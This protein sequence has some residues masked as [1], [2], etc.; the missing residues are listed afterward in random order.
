M[1]IQ[2]GD[3]ETD[4]TGQ[5]VGLNIEDTPELYQQRVDE[6]F[7]LVLSLDESIDP[8]EARDLAESSVFRAMSLAKEFNLTWPPVWHN[9][10]VNYGYRPRGLCIHFCYDL[11]TML[12]EKNYKTMQFHWGIANE[13]SSYPL[14][15]S[16][17]VVT[18]IGQ[19]FYAGVVLDA[20]RSSGK[21]TY[22]YVKGDKYEWHPFDESR[23]NVPKA[24]RESVPNK[25]K[26]GQQAVMTS[27]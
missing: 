11:I 16:S 5:L 24:S 9:V 1:P 26:G 21:L 19:D 25:L 18:A 15:H 7:E 10:L 20:W 8:I 2:Y 17:P 3:I 27:E 23:L 13:G 22:T 14:E 4:D 12:R 6:V